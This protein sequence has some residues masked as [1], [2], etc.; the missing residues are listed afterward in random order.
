VQPHLALSA[1]NAPVVAEVC[2][3]LDGIPLAIELAAARLSGL[4]LAELAARLDQRFRLLTGGSRTALPRQQTLRATVAWSYDLLTPQEQTLFARLSVFAGGWSLEAA[5][6]VGA[7]DPIGVEEVLDLLAR[8]VDKSLV[9]AEEVEDGGTRYRLLETLRQ[10]G[11]E[12]LSAAGERAAVQGRHAAYFRALVERDEQGL[13]GPDQLRWLGGMERELDN[14]RA[15]LACCLEADAP[16][17][18]GA[19]AVETGLRLASGLHAF[20]RDRDHH[21]EGLA[22]L[23]RALAQGAAAPV[24]L[25]ASASRSAGVLAAAMNDDLARSRAFLANSVALGRVLGDPW[26]LSWSLATSGWAL[27][28]S[29]HEAAA[30]AALDESL[31][32]ARTVGEPPVIAHALFHDLLRIVYGDAITRAEERARARAAGAECIQ[33]CR[34]SGATLQVALVQMHLGQVALYEGHQEQA[35]DLFVSSLPLIRALGWRTTVAEGLVGLADVARQQGGEGE[36]RTLYA[37]ALMLY[38]Q[39]G[40][41]RFPAFAAVLARQTDVALEQGDWRAAQAHVAESLA[42]AQEAGQDGTALLASALEAQAALAALRG[43]A[44]RALR[45]AGAAATLRARLPPPLAAS[46]PDIVHGAYTWQRL[47]RSLAAVE[48]APLER[49]LAPARQALSADDQATAW[50]AGQAMTPEQAVTDALAGPAPEHDTPPHR[51][52][53][54]CHGVPPAPARH[55]LA[56]ADRLTWAV[57]HLRTVGPLSP[58]AYM[59]ALGV[60]RRTAVRDLRALEAGGLVA[61]QGTTTDRRYV[62]RH[63]GP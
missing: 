34:A 31:A 17:Q 53:A 36:A 41:H 19:P 47:N 20:W 9:L 58:R 35:R 27:A 45:L 7:G 26:Q 60:E 13:P 11:Q 57:E 61:A 59:A 63:D 54:G 2:A 37:E 32:L 18:G 1:A 39:L 44:V 10:Y 42:V 52:P 51:A 22:W 4:G 29:G 56:R 48:P 8:L 46:A 24:A 62:L 49:H 40:N 43:A 3:R 5:E 33:L 50:A 14:L 15:A 21:R 12:R 16:G 25:R 6:T 38:R 28:S 55:Q 23:E 30:A